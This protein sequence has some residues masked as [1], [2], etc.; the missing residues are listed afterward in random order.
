MKV[1]F[2]DID[3]V[4]NS[5][6]WN[7]T[8]QM[9]ISDGILVDEEKVKLLSEILRTTQAKIVFHSGWKYWYN[10]DLHP[11]RYEAANLL[12]ILEKYGLKIYD[13]T[14]DLATYEIK[15]NKKFSLIKAAEILLWLEAHNDVN[16]YIV[17]DD[18]DLHND[19]ILQHQIKTD[20]S[21]GLS[22]ENVIQAIDM[23]LNY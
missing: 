12:S 16:S 17:L 2:L 4:L 10:V 22:E 19:V 23:L 20:S 14:P 1:L 13:K 11:L 18:L 8:H 3:G 5:N 7:E 6:F 15:I 9:E 21:V